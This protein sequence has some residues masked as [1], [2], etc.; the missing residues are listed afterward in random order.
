MA[1]KKKQMKNPPHPGLG[2]KV[3]CLEP[4]GLSITEGAEILGVTRQTLS[5]LVNK[6][7]ALSWDMAIRLSKAFGSTAEGWMELQFQYD[8]AQADERAK[9]IKV[10]PYQGTLEPAYQ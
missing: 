2:V 6:R 10:K 9:K 7:T 1:V 3:D 4:Y 8:V 5:L